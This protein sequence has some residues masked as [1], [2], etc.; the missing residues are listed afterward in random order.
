MPDLRQLRA[1]QAVAETGSFS[2]AA[3]TL[4]YTQPAVSKTIAGLERELGAVLVERDCRPI[5]LTDA[6]AALTRHADEVFAR[7]SSARAEIAAINQS[8]AGS[9]AIGTFG[10]AASAFVLRAVCEFRRRHPAV[11]L[12][13]VDGMPAALV[14]RLRTGD[15]DVAAVFDFP[16][17]RDEL[18]DE[19]EVQHLLDQPFDVVLP[20]SHPLADQQRIDIRDLADEEWLLP[21]LGRD[22]PMMSVISRT[23]AVAGFEPRVAFSVN[24]CRMTLAMV[25]AGGAVGILPRLLL[26]PVPAGVAVRPVDGEAPIQ[27]VAAV[28]VPNRYLSPAGRAFL[29]LLADAASRQVESWEAPD[30]RGRV[31]ARTLAA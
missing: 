26:D 1:L 3:E 2:R 6:G 19:L 23:F 4:N 5:R 15:L 10:S 21:D 14:R 31:R 7:L 27:R 29:A 25:G 24:D 22:H 17:A 28:R 13:L 16:A 8:E 12:S 9:L 30:V 11:R 20:A 18:G